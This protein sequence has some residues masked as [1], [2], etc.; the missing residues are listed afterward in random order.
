M[1]PLLALAVFAFA[2]LLSQFFR[3]AVAVVAP[4]LQADLG[5]DAAALGTLSATWF[6]AFAAMQ[7]P[8]GVALDRW[9]SRRT[10]SVLMG[11]AVLGAVVLSQADGLATAVAGQALIGIGCSPVFMGTLVAVTRWFPADR[12]ALLSSLVMAFANLG[13]L[14][15]STPFALAAELL[16]WRGALLCVAGL[17]A[18]ALL[19]VAFFGRSRTDPGRPAAHGE[20]LGEALGGVLAVMRLRP[21]WPILP[22]CFIGYA[23]LISVR[24]LWAGPYLA[25]VFALGPVARGNALLAMSV[26]MPTGVLIHV[27]LERRWQSRRKP[28]LAGSVGALA[29]LLLLA[30]L[31]DRSVLL[32]TALLSVIGACGSTYVLIVAQ[33]RQFLPAHQIGRGITLLNFANFLGAATVQQASGW[34]VQVGRDSGAAP[35]ATYG[36]LFA[37]LALLLAA[38]AAI[39]ARSREAGTRAG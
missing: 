39:F 27:W 4:E 36:W 34:V 31:A 30:L 29:G 33:S 20:S 5:L 13:I 11:V 12:F 2:Y 16:G 23:V 18:A 8:V 38:A 9:G 7:L 26:A 32:A 1:P 37:F 15:S 28:V 25:E 19:L 22:L 17:T 14:A 6:F 10:V 21:L 3:T 24:G 35:A